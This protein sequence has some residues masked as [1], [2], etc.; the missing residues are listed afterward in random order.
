MVRIWDSASGKVT[1][2]LSEKFQP[3]WL[4]FSPD[5]RLIVSVG[6][7]PF[8]STNTVKLW[9]AA[10]GKETQE[11]ARYAA[12]R[13]PG[14][15]TFS[16]DGQWLAVALEVPPANRA[17][18]TLW[19]ARARPL[20]RVRPLNVV[21]R[22]PVHL[23]F[24]PESRRLAYVGLSARSAQSN[25]GLGEL[26]IWQTDTAEVLVSVEDLPF[27]PNNG[28][29]AFSPDGKQ[30]A[31]AAS[32]RGVHLLDAQT[33][34]ERTALRADGDSPVGLAYRPDGK[35]LASTGSD[36]I[37]Q[38][39][40]PLSYKNVRTVRAEPVPSAMAFSPDGRRLMTCSFL[41]RVAVWDPQTGQD[42]LTLPV[43]GSLNK[44]AVSPDGG[45]LACV[46]QGQDPALTI[47]DP[48][49][50]QRLLTL[51]G[52]TYRPMGVAFSPDGRLLATNGHDGRMILWDPATGQLRRTLQ[53]ERGGNAVAFSPDG[54]LLAA[55]VH[56]ATA[57]HE[58][59]GKVVL[60][61]VASGQTVRTL[62]GH[63][64]SIWDVE[65]SP[66][67]RRL[68]T[69]SGDQTA[70]VWDVRTGQ[71]LLSLRGHGQVII[72]AK[73]SPDGRRIATASYDKTVK[74]WETDT[75]ALIHTLRGQTAMISGV[76][77]SRDGRRI[78][79][80]SC[81]G[82]IKIWDAASGEELLTLRGPAS[83]I[84]SVVF[85]PEDQWIA[86]CWASFPGSTDIDHT[87]RLWEA[88]PPTP[89]RRLQREAAALVNDLPTNLGFKEEIVAY[90]RSLPSIGE[91]LR[92]H[93]LTMAEGLP[94]DP[95]R[96]NLASYQAVRRP[97]LD[98]A[99]YRLA[100]RQAEA[101]RDLAHPGFIFDRYHHP[102]TSIGIAHYRLE[103]YRQAVDALSSSQA[104][105]LTRSPGQKD[106]QPLNLAFLVMAQRRLGEEEKAQAALVRL[107]SVMRDPAWASRDDLHTFMREA[108][109]LIVWGAPSPTEEERRLRREAADLVDKL[110]ADL[111]FKD[112]IL[113]HLCT[114]PTL[115]E[116]LREHAL[117][118]VE[119][120]PED[121][122]RMNNLANAYQAAG[123]HDRALPLLEEILKL[124]KATLG[125]DHPD[126]LQGMN[127][128]GFCLLNA[129]QYDR[130]LPLIKE[131]LELRKSRL[132]ADHPDTLQ[133]MNNLAFC[134]YS[135]GQLDRALPLWEETVPL[136]KAKLGAD[137]PQALGTTNNL[138]NAYRDAG[139]YDRELPL[140]Q[141]LAEL[142]KGKAGADSLQY[143]GALAAL[144]LNLL[145]Q[146]KW[147]EAESV[148]RQVLA[149]RETKAP[150]D[151]STFNAKQMLGGALLGQ[152]QYA[153]AEPLL[154]DGYE[155]LKQRA[156]RIPPLWKQSIAE[157]LARLITLAE[158]TNKPDEARV[159]KD[160]RAKVS[161]ASAPKPEAENP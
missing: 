12:G 57:E 62:S 103:E 34:K 124:R 99:R 161:G 150:D 74:V 84:F 72:Q 18:V 67:G 27:A 93:A 38:L 53:Y 143:A 39:W 130:A 70:G 116:P 104:Y 46:S 9:D 47:W 101:A 44:L 85:G 36:G 48:A 91:P 148:L 131:T 152:K 100:L 52:H 106:G 37:V 159:W 126:T 133:S 127:S 40:D 156:E 75:G 146:E 96:L 23:A 58:P 22:T 155:G 117:A 50:G 105:Y 123:K 71:Q 11:L 141:E 81:D 55:T 82:T 79:A 16:P 51:H 154:R 45:R 14:V 118:M 128:L 111:G 113:F 87:I 20:K 13:R 32:D 5:A 64:Q 25:S 41:N 137:H 17:A 108:E 97:G 92:Q 134:Y 15:A 26:K 95:W 94:E 86:S 66:D 110:P 49:T 121:P 151:W 56:S 6:W 132:G 77:F 35:L 119:R 24:S 114:L 112:E 31:L 109:E 4:E 125:P 28:S 122:W 76:G 158:A 83:N 68:V 63:P 102:T 29:V 73:F 69:A 65:F 43:N 3:L 145:R 42:P 19:D 115:R 21:T 2:E 30:L 78:A 88:T 120:L 1:H 80:G 54:Q 89:E 139:K 61:S 33:G 147:A 136:R 90:L 160:E 8:T 157:V 144:G 153:A 129:H 98:A 7:Y 138:A 59:V 10:T 140:R 142:W 107:H 60:S 135:T 149:I